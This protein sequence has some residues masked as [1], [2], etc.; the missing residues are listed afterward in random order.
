MVALDKIKGLVYD[1]LF[2]VDSPIIS[3]VGL[4]FFCGFRVSTFSSPLRN[5]YILLS[6]HDLI[7]VLALH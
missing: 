1:S 4:R 5:N 3:A 2:A 6:V 7:T